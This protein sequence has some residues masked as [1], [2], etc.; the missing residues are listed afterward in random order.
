MCNMKMH[1]SYPSK[2]R[3]LDAELSE[4]QKHNVCGTS[5]AGLADVVRWAYWSETPCSKVSERGRSHGRR[6]TVDEQATAVAWE[7]AS[8]AQS[9]QNSKAG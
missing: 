4:V 1:E 8:I 6:R 3:I 5:A 2:F 7:E 9:F